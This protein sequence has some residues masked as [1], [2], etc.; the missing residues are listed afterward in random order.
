MVNYTSSIVVNEGDSIKLGGDNFNGPWVMPRGDTIASN[1]VLESKTA[2]TYS[3]SSIPNDGF[4]Y[5]VSIRS[6]I[7]TSATSGEQ[8]EVFVYTGT[9]TSSFY[10][11][12][13]GCVPRAANAQIGGSTCIIPVLASQDRSI[14]F[15]NNGDYATGSCSFYVMGYRRIG[16]NGNA[17]QYISKVNVK[18]TATTIGG[19]NF[20]G[21]WVYKSTTLVS[22]TSITNGTYT[23]VDLSSYLPNDTYNYEILFAA[24]CQTGT[25][26]NNQAILRLGESTRVGSCTMIGRR[27]TQHAV[28]TLLAGNILY[29]TKKRSVLLWND[30]TA[31][32][33][34][35]NLYAR[36]Y[37]RLGRNMEDDMT[38]TLTITT[39]PSNATVDFYSIGQISGKKTTVMKGVRVYYKV[40]AS[41]YADVDSNVLVNSN[42]NKTVSLVEQPYDIDEVVFESSTAGTYSVDLAANGKYEVICI[43][44]GGGGLVWKRSGYASVEYG[45][46]S[47]SGFDCVLQLSTGTY[48]IV[49]GKGGT[50]LKTS[51]TSKDAESGGNS[52]FGTSYA[53]GG[54]GGLHN[55]NKAPGGST[56]TVSYTIVS[57]I[58]NKAGNKGT[59]D[60]SSTAAGGKSVY[61][62]T[63]T[64]YGA[65]GRS[66]QNGYAGYVKIIYKGT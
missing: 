59:N 4:D 21:P 6:F 52:Q 36:G 51:S 61:D 16:K 19:D 58:F 50:L 56:P 43:A 20:D 18:G 34:S 26:A 65:G 49:V 25:A 31:V 24:S 41:G 10:Q 38:A 13:D 1:L 48:S 66:N 29:P 47:G 60:A 15:Y 8:C 23:T 7:L 57:T 45:G 54:S 64:G 37:R 32:A 3:L 53:Y 28:Y 30:G 2:Y 27:K 12:I 35:V 17:N 5:E 14:T 40:S 62:N 39:I 42:T 33:N 11:R 9:G 22:S 46:G 55:N 63:A 44:G